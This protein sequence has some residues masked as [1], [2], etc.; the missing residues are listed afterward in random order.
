MISMFEFEGRK[1]LTK[2]E[3]AARYGYS[4]NWFNRQ[5]TLH[6]PPEAIKSDCGRVYYDLDKTD[7]WFR[8]AMHITKL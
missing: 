6:R 3:A 7:E 4:V 1:Y 2:K 8:S 5:R